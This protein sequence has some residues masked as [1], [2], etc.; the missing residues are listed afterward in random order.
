MTKGE[1]L[2]HRLHIKV[3]KLLEFM[4]HQGLFFQK[5]GPLS[6]SDLDF[7]KRLA[8]PVLHQHQPY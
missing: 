6:L 1:K 3:L 2:K 7:G 4:A 5:F 8:T